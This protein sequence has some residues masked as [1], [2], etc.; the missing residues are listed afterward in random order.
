MENVISVLSWVWYNF[1]DRAAMFMMVLVL[2]GQLLTKRPVLSPLWAPWKAYIGYIVYQTATGGLYNA[3]Q[4]IMMGMRNV[5]GMNLLVNDDSLGAGTLTAILE[6]FGRTSPA[7]RWLPWRQA[8]FFAILLVLLKKKY[9]KCR[10][11]IIQAHIPVGQAIDMVPILLV[12]FPLM[13]DFT[14][15]LAVG[16]FLA[17]K[18]CVLSNL[19]VEPAQDLTDGANMCVGHTQMILDR[20]GYEYGR[21]LER[22]GQEKG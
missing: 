10:S 6:G 2:I 1:F 13:N 19:T 9:T 18:W 3:F 15:I 16:L 12:M 14:V 5:L 11:L 8:L 22:K 7:C 21:Y 4:P 20:I 17:V